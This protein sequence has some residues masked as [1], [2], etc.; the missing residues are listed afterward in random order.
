[1]IFRPACLGRAFRSVSVPGIIS[2]L[3]ITSRLNNVPLVITEP[4]NLF[5]LSGVHLPQWNANVFCTNGTQMPFTPMAYRSQIPF[6]PV[7]H[8]WQWHTDVIHA[9]GFQMPFTPMAFRC[10][11]RQLPIQ[12]QYES[13][14][15]IYTIGIQ[16]S[17][18]PTEFRPMACISSLYQYASRPLV[19]RFHPCHR[20]SCIQMLFMST[21]EEQ[22]DSEQFTRRKSGE[23]S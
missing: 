22:D 6:T 2:L 23:R 11:S 5:S 8:L 10:Y 12:C 16:K 3:P 18:M 21:T 17:F 9:N 14:H 15:A 1:M 13:I 7:R 20:E 4:A 19:N